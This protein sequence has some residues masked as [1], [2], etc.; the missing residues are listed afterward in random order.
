MYLWK[1]VFLKSLLTFLCQREGFPLFGRRGHGRESK[2][3]GDSIPRL[4]IN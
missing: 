2:G 1:K 3:H 4:M